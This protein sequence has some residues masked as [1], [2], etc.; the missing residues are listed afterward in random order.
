[1]ARRKL[2]LEM[3]WKQYLY[4]Q[5]ARMPDLHEGKP[6]VKKPV[7]VWREGKLSKAVT[8]LSPD[9]RPLNLDDDLGDIEDARY[10]N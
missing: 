4:G 10:G 2:P 8:Y 9:Y 6:R 1:M 3:R 7:V 5:T